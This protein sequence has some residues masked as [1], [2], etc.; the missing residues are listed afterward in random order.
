[1]LVDEKEGNIMGA[2]LI[3]ANAGELINE[4]SLAMNTGQTVED[5][6]RSCHAHPTFSEIIKEAALTACERGI[7]S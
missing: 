4:I 5:V 2:H 7:H 3:G 1:L 6:A